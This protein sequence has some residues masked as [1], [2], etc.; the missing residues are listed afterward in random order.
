MLELI[1]AR[2]DERHS[3]G[4]PGASVQA[5]HFL[6][7]ALDD[8]PSLAPAFEKCLPLFAG[9]SLADETEGRPTR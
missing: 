8:L 1:L 3:C 6:S 2:V 9:W 4:P 7:R 5:R